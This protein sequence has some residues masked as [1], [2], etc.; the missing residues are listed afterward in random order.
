MDSPDRETIG[1]FVRTRRQANRMTLRELSELA[2]V[3]PRA[4]WELEHDKATLRLD[5]AN[6][7]LKVF[8]KQV[9]VVDAPRDVE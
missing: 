7:V 2:G 9:G 1:R 6:A 3:G 4:L 5:I 8:G